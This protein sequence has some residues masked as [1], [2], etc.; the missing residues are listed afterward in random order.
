[1]R[2]I[3]NKENILDKI[4]YI[5]QQNGIKGYS[6]F[7][8]FSGTTSVAQYFKKLNYTVYSSDILYMSYC[9]QKA[10][11]ENND[12]P[13]F[14]KLLNYLPTVD[15]NTLL[16]T[17]LDYVIY[18][19]DNITPL[20]GFIYKHY[21]PEGTE[22]LDKPRMYFSSENGK[23]IDAIRFQIEKWKKEDLIL[24]NEYYILISCLIETISF[25]ANISGVYAAFNKRWDPRA[26]KP[27]YLRKINIINN[28]KNN[29]VYN[30][31]SIS[32][33]N[34][35][36]VDILYLDPPYNKRQYLPN[37][38]ILE[39]I[40]KYDNPF[41]KG[42]TGMREYQYQKS[43]FCNE[44]TALKS[45]EY[46]VSNANCK[47]IVLSYN[48]EGIMK[49]SDIVAI[50]SKYGIVKLEEFSNTRFKSN[51]KGL[52]KTKKYINEQVYLVI[53]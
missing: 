25:Y 48:S 27:L 2:Y 9:L 44:L 14:N 35:T 3:G 45:L 30:C 13:R 6:F 12:E 34:N 4:Y 1:M 26:L 49:Q 18:Y 41:I 21:T 29:Y 23:K 38:H 19:L 52:S 33:I 28:N 31:D 43:S 10:Y 22:D 24:E 16:A 53:K 17:P 8:F 36:H 37:Y 39:T 46:I 5:M 11:I 40:A 47:Y 42:V 15:C 7:D 32:L 51:N 20:E 50:L